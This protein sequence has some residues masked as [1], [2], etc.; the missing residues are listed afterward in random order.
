MNY[1]EGLTLHNVV[2]FKDVYLPLN[3][4]GV[5]KIQGLNKDADKRNSNDN[6]NA[7]GKSF[8]TSCIPQIVVGTD[9][10]TQDVKARAKKDFFSDKDSSMSLAWRVGTPKAP[11]LSVEKK[12]KGKSFEYVFK[13]DGVDQKVRKISYS[14]EKLKKHFPYTEEEFFTLYYVDSRRPNALQF[15]SPTQRLEY[16][17]NLFKLNNYDEIRKLFNGM[18]NSLKKDGIVLNEV[19]A[20]LAKLEEEIGEAD[21]AELTAQYEKTKVKQK[22]YNDAIHNLYKIIQL[23][24]IVTSN[25]ESMQRFND[26]TVELDFANQYADEESLR[27]HCK[28][29]TATIK[30]LSAL[31]KQAAKYI[32]YLAKKEQYDAQYQALREKIAKVKGGFTKHQAKQHEADAEKAAEIRAKID[33]LK[34]E[35]ETSD[36]DVEFFD[37]YS[38]QFKEKFGEPTVKSVNKVL[39]EYATALSIEQRYIRDKQLSINELVKLKDCPECPTCNQHVDKKMLAKWIDEGKD[40]IAKSKDK[41]KVLSGKIEKVQKF[42]NLFE[43]HEAYSEA[44]VAQKKLKGLKATLEILVKAISGGVEHYSNYQKSVKYREQMDSLVLP[45]EVEKPKGD[46]SLLPQL[47]EWLQLYAVVNHIYDKYSHAPKDIEER[48]EQAEA[49]MSALKKKSAK[50][51]DNLS[52]V[53]SRLEVLKNN[54][55][56]LKDLKTRRSELVKTTQD[57]PIVELLIDAYSNKGVKLLIIKQIASIIE[58]NM[59][60][61]APLL[62]KEK[63]KFTFEVEANC[64]NILM[65]RNYK[66]KP[67]TADVRRLSGAE[68]RAFSFLLPLAILPL[69][70]SE[71]RL[72]IMVLDEP[73]VNLDFSMKTLF[74]TSFIP[75]LNSVIPHIIIVSPLDDVYKNQKSYT[76]VKESGFSTL[77]AS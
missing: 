53:S 21:I 16:F 6:T 34:K 38:N 63:I 37:K 66:G 4:K 67:R 60:K 43:K 54:K 1:L 42:L 41:Q 71:R 15:G 45:E 59:N 74:T 28:R 13:T 50:C 49:D 55:T 10:V 51:V 48:A 58:K 8:L 14:E 12:A 11:L 5:T 76:V 17:T 26:L 47:R 73:T 75:K 69:I 27:K 32:E 44:Q 33:R 46:Y 70:P 35:I 2:L 68:S 39:T 23:G 62:Y 9:S 72:N 56:R 61:F 3:H 24:S 22:K 19:E 18:L 36:F 52:K 65:T 31:E 77:V 7:A 57:I 25:K 40:N 64:F 20:S 29:V 30:E